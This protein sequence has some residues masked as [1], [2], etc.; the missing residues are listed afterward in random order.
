M[1]D[2]PSTALLKE[3]F[4]DGLVDAYGMSE[5]GSCI[6]RLPG[7]KLYQVNSDTHVVNVYNADLSGKSD[8]GMAVITPLLKIDMPLINYATLDYVESEM[9]DGLR[10][11]SR[12][13]G[14]MND[15]I[16]HANGGVTEW[17]NISVV[18]NYTPEVIAYRM[19][20]KSID[21]VHMLMV[22]NPD[23]PESEIPAVEQRLSEGLAGI[24][25]DPGMNLSMEWV[26]DIPSDPNGKLRVIVSEM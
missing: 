19:I 4:G 1:L 26:A 11:V 20:Q 16:H 9:K 12:I 23:T 3:V 14:R 2:I 13:Q 15:G 17:A 22:R 5:T 6:V 10:F 25:K 8:K 7:Q 21:H 24:F 18:M